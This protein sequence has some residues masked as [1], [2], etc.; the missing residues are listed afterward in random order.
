[1]TLKD[2]CSGYR[3]V[4][5]LKSTTEVHSALDNMISRVEKETGRK[6]ISFRSDNGREFKNEKVDR[7]LAARGIVQERSAPHVKQ[8]NGIAERENRILCDTARSLLYNADLSRSERL[9]L[10]GEAIA[11]SAYLRNRVPNKRTNGKTP[12]ELWF[13]CKPDVSHIH[14]F[15]SPAFVKIPETARKQMD[16][17]SKKTVFVGFDQNTDKILRVFD[18]SVGLT[19]RVDRVS[20]T[21]RGCGFRLYGCFSHSSHFRNK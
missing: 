4:T 21:G 1:M 12:Y 5:L 17:K 7:L 15:G 9:R 3:L 8:G 6:V 20:V 14:V 19:S 11:T 18:R 16:P 13:G 2:E 10:W